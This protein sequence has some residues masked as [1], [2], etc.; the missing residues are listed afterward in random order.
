MNRDGELAAPLSQGAVKA[1]STLRMAGNIGF[2]LQLVFGVL[3]AVLLLLA[4]AGLTAAGDTKTIQ[5]AGF[6]LF[7]AT[8][9]ILALIISLIFFFRYRKI[10]Q[11]IQY[12]DPAIRP[13]KKSTLQAIKLG[14]VA[15]LLGMLLAILGAESFVGVLWQ[16]LSSLPQG[17]TIY[18]TSQLPQPN[19]ILLVLANTHTIFCHFIGIVIALLLL[20]R[21]NK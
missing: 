18:N 6:S 14:L 3:A 12:G 9:G 17:T 11:L 15:N 2:W 8:G 21:L 5:G 10:A 4:A 20:D 13:H 19:E 7:C 16:K 1:A